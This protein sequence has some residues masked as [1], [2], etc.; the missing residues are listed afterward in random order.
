VENLI[1]TFVGTLVG[2]AVTLWV[3]RHYYMKAGRDLESAAAAL[4]RLTTLII[5]GMEEAG[6]ATFTRDAAGYPISR[7]IEA[8]ANIV[9][10]S[11]LTASLT[12]QSASLESAPREG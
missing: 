2:G 3:S 5:R 10:T 12:L 9:G 7:V 1:S 11:N 6:L 4:R 8:S